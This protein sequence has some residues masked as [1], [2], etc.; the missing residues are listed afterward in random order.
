MTVHRKLVE[1][2]DRLKDILLEVGLLEGI[3]SGEK[4]SCQEG[5]RGNFLVS[6]CEEEK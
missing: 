5:E 1:A 6:D 4:N 3:R 2:L